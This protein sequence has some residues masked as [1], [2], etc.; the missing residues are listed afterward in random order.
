MI[1][2]ALEQWSAKEDEQLRRKPLVI[3]ELCSDAPRLI[4][5]MLMALNE[6]P[7]VALT[8]H[9]TLAELTKRYEAL[10]VNAAEII[11]LRLYSGASTK[12]GA[13][14]AGVGAPMGVLAGRG[15]CTDRLT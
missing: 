12:P 10:D 15:G 8:V 7:A 6:D 2:G 4:H 3:Q 5:E 9:I 1:R 11:S 14:R 13:G